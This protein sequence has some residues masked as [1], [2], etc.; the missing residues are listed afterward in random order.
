V[1]RHSRPGPPRPSHHGRPAEQKTE[2]QG[3][4]DGPFHWESCSPGHI[5]GYLGTNR[6]CLAPEASRTRPALRA[7]L[8]LWTRGPAI[9]FRTLR[10]LVTRVPLLALRTGRP[11]AA[12]RLQGLRVHNDG[13]FLVQELLCLCNHPAHFA[14]AHVCR[15]FEVV[16]DINHALRIHTLRVDDVG[17]ECSFRVALR[18]RGTVSARLVTSGSL[19][20]DRRQARSQSLA[21]DREGEPVTHS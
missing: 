14:T 17:C 20:Q 13:Q 8:P 5:G 6:P 10:A 1:D 18:E 21:E 4:S 9:P 2:R 7:L 11:R 15:G 19:V 12:S 3:T 16:H